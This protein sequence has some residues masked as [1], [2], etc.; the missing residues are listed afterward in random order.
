MRMGMSIR[1]HVWLGAMLCATLLLVAFGAVASALIGQ[2]SPPAESGRSLFLPLALAGMVVLAVFAPLSWW[3]ARLAYAPVRDVTK[4]ARSI[5]TTG[6]LDRRCFYPGP[7]DDVGEL[8][9]SVNGLLV[10]YDLAVGR[11][12]R[13]EAGRAGCE[14]PRDEP[15]FDPSDFVLDLKSHDEGARAI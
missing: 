2:L 15:D 14:C 13:L 9:V 6:Q 1:L 11:I 4:T 7:R 10:C 8:V 12:R 5:M 3:L